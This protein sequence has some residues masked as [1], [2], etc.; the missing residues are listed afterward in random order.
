[1]Q[2]TGGPGLHPA[3]NTVYLRISHGGGAQEGRGKELHRLPAVRGLEAAER[4][5]HSG[6]IPSTGDRG[7]LQ[8]DGGGHYIFQIGLA[9]RVPPDAGEGARSVQNCIL[10]GEHNFMGMAGRSFGAEECPALLSK[11]HGSDPAGSTILQ[12]LH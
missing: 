3:L 2:E 8:S 7:H 4:G 6:P 10:E 9:E 11:A 5:D 1:M 12:M